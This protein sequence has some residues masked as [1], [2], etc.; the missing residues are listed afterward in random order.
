MN[1]FGW[2]KRCRRLKATIH[3]LRESNA[4]LK[5]RVSELEAQIR[6]LTEALAGAK[7]TSST[8]SK[9]PSSDIVKPSRVKP[10]GK[11]RRKAR[12]IGGQKGH[13]KHERPAFTPGQINF[14]IPHR[15]SCCPV[16]PSHRLV[17]EPKPQKILQ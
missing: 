16:D 15:L 2:K 8:S 6:Q 13:P 11:R 10:S 12:K 14:R 3:A 17:H 7:K 9:P 1:L 4:K 5:T